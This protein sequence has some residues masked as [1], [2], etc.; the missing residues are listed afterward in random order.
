MLSPF[1]RLPDDLT[2]FLKDPPKLLWL[3]IVLYHLNLP[4]VSHST[5]YHIL[6]CTSFPRTSR[7]VYFLVSFVSDS[8]DI[9]H[10]HQTSLRVV[11]DLEN[12]EDKESEKGMK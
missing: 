6:W 9:P 10:L 1:V 3:K 12:R 4:D 11:T 2:R 7:P 5:V 8:Q